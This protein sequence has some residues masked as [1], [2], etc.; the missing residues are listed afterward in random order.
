MQNSRALH[1][2]YLNPGKA[3]WSA[4]C[5]GCACA[6]VGGGVIYMQITVPDMFG[7][8]LATA[9]DCELASLLLCLLPPM[10][11]D[12]S[13]KAPMLHADQG[14]ALNVMNMIQN[15]IVKARRE[16]P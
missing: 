4:F 1:L 15:N 14:G 3:W 9:I 6:Q 5:S 16:T 12:S 10:M 7:Q 8:E 13:L 11:H 2:V